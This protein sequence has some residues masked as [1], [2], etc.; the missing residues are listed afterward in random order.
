MKNDE[1][2]LFRRPTLERTRPVRNFGAAYRVPD[3]SGASLGGVPLS[4]ME[5]S[6]VAF[7][8]TVYKVADAGVDRSARLAKRLRNAGDRAVGP[9]SGRKA[10][11]STE[12]LVFRGLMA[13][14]G[15]LEALGAEEGSPLQ[16]LAAAQYELLGSLLF[17]KPRKPTATP[18]PQAAA[19]AEERTVRA[20]QARQNSSAVLRIAHSQARPRAVNVVT[21]ELEPGA[22]R[23]RVYLHHV[24]DVAAEPVEASLTRTEGGATLALDTTKLTPAGLWRAPVCDPDGVQV[25]V[26]EIEL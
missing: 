25:G 18:E 19:P 3:K 14:L 23:E 8:R 1:P 9:R 4:T 5:D 16:R 26:M 12:Q 2:L 24:G 17:V 22:M 10:L 7:V 15:W 11:D 21:F 20:A 13:A 6:A